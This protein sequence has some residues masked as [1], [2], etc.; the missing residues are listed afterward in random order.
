MAKVVIWISADLYSR[1]EGV[2][3]GLVEEVMCFLGD[4][5]NRAI[6]RQ[7]ETSTKDV[8]EGVRKRLEA[9][10]TG[11]RKIL[12]AYGTITS[13]INLK[14]RPVLRHHSVTTRGVDVQIRR[15]RGNLNG[16]GDWSGQ[17]GQVSLPEVPFL[18]VA[19]MRCVNEVQTR[20]EGLMRCGNGPHIM[21]ICAGESGIASDAGNGF[22]K[23]T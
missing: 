23:I 13:P 22:V 18:D 19:H 14:P 20:V 15:A 17:E 2:L 3:S 9:A 1:G 21:A 10:I 16:G 11:G 6:V 8:E 4:I 12:D 7:E 5:F